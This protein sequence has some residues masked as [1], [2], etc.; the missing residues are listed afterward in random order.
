MRAGNMGSWAWSIPQG[1]V[2]GDPLIAEFFGFDPEEEPWPIENFFDGIVDDDV[3]YVRPEVERSI[4]QDDDYITEFRVKR[5]DGEPTLWLAARGRVVERGPDGEPLL[6]LG[7]NWDITPEKEQERRLQLLASEMDHRV[8]NAFAVMRSLIRLAGRSPDDPK[9]L[10]DT[11]GAQCQAMADAHSLSA[12]L[13]RAR[14]LGRK[15]E[16]SDVAALIDRALLPWKRS[17]DARAIVEINAERGIVLPDHGLQAIAMIIY[18]LTTNAAKHGA[19]ALDDGQLVV[20][21]TRR[22]DNKMKLVWHETVPEG[23][24]VRKGDGAAKPD[25]RGFGT[26]LIEQC[27]TTLRGTLERDLTPTGLRLTLVFPDD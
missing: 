16:G 8:K 10:A 9:D 12:R 18:E 17:G 19:L 6:M 15:E 24:L 1:V 22:D 26:T 11:L 2:R 23:P 4:V 3:A 21:L 5:P 14:S 20:T 13:S 27:V 7:I 25:R